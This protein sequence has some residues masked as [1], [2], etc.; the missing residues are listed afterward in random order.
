MCKFLQWLLNLRKPIK[1]NILAVIGK[2][3]VFSTTTDL[4]LTNRDS[5]QFCFMQYPLK[6]RKVMMLFKIVCT[7]LSNIFLT[8][9]ILCSDWTLI[10]T[11]SF[12]YNF[13]YLIEKNL[14]RP[15]SASLPFN[16][17]SSFTANILSGLGPVRNVLSY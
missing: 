1:F 10:K 15:V 4:F 12:T 16:P 5:D 3:A 6:V 11:G 13:I 7:A 17:C 9:E 2:L 8:G 14:N